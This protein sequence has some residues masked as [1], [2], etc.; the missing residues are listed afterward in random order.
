MI[1]YRTL[2]VVILF[3]MVAHLSPAIN[4]SP[5]GFYKTVDSKE[6]FTTS[7][8]AVYEWREEL[9]GRIIVSF[10]EKDGDFLESYLAPKKIAHKVANAPLLLNMDFFYGFTQAD[11]KWINGH[12][13]D[14]RSGAIYKGQVWESDEGLILRG[15]FGPFGLK[16]LFYPAYTE[17]FPEWVPVPS[18]SS[19]IPYTSH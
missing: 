11:E 12:I 2:V 9:F 13:I 5:I 19:F 18:L 17:D 16:Y 6:N 7:I 8:I 15:M 4:S 3:I 1:R 14:V 10:D